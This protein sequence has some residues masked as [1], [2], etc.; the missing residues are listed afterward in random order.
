MQGV[1]EAQNAA[2]EESAAVPNKSEAEL[3][4]PVSKILELASLFALTLHQRHSR[5]IITVPSGQWKGRL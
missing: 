2:A 1:S 5:C 3:Q 4:V